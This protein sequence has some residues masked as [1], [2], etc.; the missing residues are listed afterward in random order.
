MLGG[1]W[2]ATIIRLIPSLAP[3]WLMMSGRVVAVWSRQR[4]SRRLSRKIFWNSF[5]GGVQGWNG[6]CKNTVVLRLAGSDGGRIR[7]GW[8]RYWRRHSWNTGRILL[9]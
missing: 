6:T 1:L 7:V 2:Y 8:E 4:G 5:D 9:G 3:S